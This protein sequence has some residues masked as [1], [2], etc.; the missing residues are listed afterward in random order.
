MKILLALDCSH[1]SEELVAEVLEQAWPKGAHFDVL[2]V[3]EPAHAW[4]Q[5]LPAE[6]LNAKAH[7][8]VTDAVF[9]LSAQGLTCERCFREGDAKK[10]IL[11]FAEENHPD[12]ILVGA[13][14]RSNSSRF[15][16]GS[17]SAA[18]VRHAKCSVQIV[19]ARTHD[20]RAERSYRILAATDGSDHALKAMETLAARPLR[21]GTEIRVVSVIELILPP[22]L[23]MLE[24]GDLGFPPDSGDF[25][26]AKKEAHG[27]ATRAMQILSRVCS[28][29]SEALPVVSSGAKNAILEEAERWDA[30]CIFVGSHGRRGLDRFLLGSVSEAVATHA[31]CSVEVVR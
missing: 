12:L 13:R 21:P 28:H 20:F 10:E 25:N 1:G 4:T 3:M 2:H 19:R 6:A 17:V 22:T 26:E 14:R 31:K 7:E 27:N 8:V 11:S 30:D 29:I 24:P 23:T 9:S 16:M 15:L 18:V 5:A